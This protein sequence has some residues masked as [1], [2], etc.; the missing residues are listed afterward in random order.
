MYKA[1]D[2]F[3]SKETKLLSSVRPETRHLLRPGVR[4]REEGGHRP[5]RP[6]ALRTQCSL[7]WGWGEEQDT[8]INTI[9]K[10]EAWLLLK[11]GSQQ[12]LGRVWVMTQQ[13]KLA[14]ILGRSPVRTRPLTE[15]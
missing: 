15:P 5:G 9:G 4:D 13:R 14:G 8:L 7:R 6:T 10:P 1:K 3:G 12:G 2:M 11:S